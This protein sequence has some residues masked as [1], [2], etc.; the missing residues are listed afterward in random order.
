MVS[1]VLHQKNGEQPSKLLVISHDLQQRNVSKKAPREL[2][3]EQDEAISEEDLQAWETERQLQELQTEVY[4]E[5][6]LIEASN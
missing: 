4:E 2:L 6:D 5:V 3:V 1:F